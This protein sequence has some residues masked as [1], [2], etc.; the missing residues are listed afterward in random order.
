[1][2]HLSRVNN[3]KYG[4]GKNCEVISDELNIVGNVYLW[5][6]NLEMD[7]QNVQL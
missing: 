4:E 6:L 3:Y 2:Y 7:Y 5:K 1:M